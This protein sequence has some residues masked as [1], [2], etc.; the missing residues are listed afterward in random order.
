MG[1]LGRDVRC[2]DLF[3]GAG[4]S[5]CGAASAGASIVGGVD[6]WD[7]AASTFG[8]NFPA[9]QVWN[10]RL[11]QLRPNEV[12]ATLGHV[13]LLVASPECTNH[14]FAKGNRRNGAEQEQSRQTAFQVIRFVNDLRPRWVVVENVVSMKRWV[15]Y[16]KWKS[17]LAD[18]TS[19]P[20]SS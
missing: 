15:E 13:D 20:P 14:T 6:S 5:S 3:C 8:L 7:L 18:V 17:E 16:G 4:G 12:N 1:Q 10:T 9:A 2:L 11:E 19:H